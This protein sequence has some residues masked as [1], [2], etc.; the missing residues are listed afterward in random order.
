MAV[1]R[2]YN[3]LYGKILKENDTVVFDDIS[4]SVCKTYLRNSIDNER[5]FKL[6]SIEDR[7]HFC[8]NNYHYTAGRGRWPEY[9]ANDYEAATRVVLALYVE[10]DKKLNNVKSEIGHK[11]YRSYNE[12]EGNTLK[13][14]D[15]LY[16]GSLEYKVFSANLG[17]INIPNNKIFDHL[18][19]NDKTEF[20]TKAYGYIADGTK[21][22]PEC[23]EKDFNALTRVALALY[24]EFEA[25]VNKSTAEDKPKVYTSYN[26][27]KG[28]TLEKDDKVYFGDLEYKVCISF[29]STPRHNNR[30]IFE[31]LNITDKVS[32]C[33]ACYR[34]EA[35]AGG[36]FPNCH[37]YDYEAL[38]RVTLKLFEFYEK[39]IINKKQ[40]I[41]HQIQQTE[42]NEEFSFSNVKPIK[43]KF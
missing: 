3:D 34:Y 18:G 36:D 42:I 41:Q 25:K 14:Y 31:E 29:L 24:K 33:T 5:I 26:E 11:T 30:K 7:Q 21:Y 38:T 8:T 4:Y 23:K 37:N 32:F 35:D 43:V 10:L 22:F 20:C 19:I 16:F 6:L 28:R 39:S 17:G 40:D 13:Y 1:Y 15:T 12:L 27:L 9:E 2:C